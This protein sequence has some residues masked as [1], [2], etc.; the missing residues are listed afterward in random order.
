MAEPGTGAVGLAGNGHAARTSNTSWALVTYA[1]PTSTN[2]GWYLGD[3]IA[4]F[5]SA[6]CF[7]GPQ[8]S[9]GAYIACTGMSWSHRDWIWA[10]AAASGALLE[11]KATNSVWPIVSTDLASHG[12]ARS[13][14]RVSCCASLDIVGSASPSR[15]RRTALGSRQS[16]HTSASTTQWAGG[17]ARSVA[18]S[19]CVALKS[20][21]A[22]KG[23]SRWTSTVAARSTG[24]LRHSSTTHA[25]M[26]C[27]TR[28]SLQPSSS[29]SWRSCRRLS[30]ASL[31]MLSTPPGG[32]VCPKLP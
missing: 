22:R 17:S 31:W 11:S 30:S 14:S 5:N 4:S 1:W 12:F 7:R 13:V 8:W 2:T 28:R 25:P 10:D 32:G 20:L 21:R 23:K 15:R 3:R 18:M 27:P 6:I 19:R 9:F 16:S 24:S 29:T 26:E